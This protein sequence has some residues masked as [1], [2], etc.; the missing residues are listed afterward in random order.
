[1]EPYC[2]RPQFMPCCVEK[3][4]TGAYV[5]LLR[6]PLW[7]VS[8]SS[9][10]DYIAQTIDIIYVAIVG[11]NQNHKQYQCAIETNPTVC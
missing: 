6:A 5:A 9:L 10:S 1:M 11:V 2:E 7:P 4:A 3:Q 8:P